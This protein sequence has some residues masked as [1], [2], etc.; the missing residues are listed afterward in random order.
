M[1]AISELFDATTIVVPCSRGDRDG[2][3]RDGAAPLQGHQLTVLPTTPPMGSGLRR[4]LQFPVWLLRNSATI[5]RA[6]RNADA[7]HAPIPGDVGTIG[8]VLAVV[9]RKPLFVRHCGNWL[10]PR[11]TAEHFWRWFV[12]RFAGGRN[13]MLATGGTAEAPSA[14][15][16]N[17][18]WIFSTSMS[19]AELQLGES[20]CTPPPAAARLI[21]VCRQDKAKG[22]DT[23]IDSL[24]LLMQGLPGIG[25]DVV[26]DG[27]HLEALRNRAASLGISD[28]VVFHGKQNHEAVLRLLRAAHL[29]VYPTRASEG[30]PKVVLEALACGLPVVTTR[31]SVL[32]QLLAD[33]A[34][35]L[36]DESVPAA[37]ARAVS[38]ALSDPDRYRRMSAS[39]IETAR[40]FSLERWR[41]TIGLA[42]RGAWGTPLRAHA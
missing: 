16:P 11:T 10:R 4:K 30:F 19:E 23:V 25:L 37:V 34:G 14:I 27:D 32:P 8:M 42:L 6:I 31:V 29:F 20:R 17:V 36:L 40:G 26:G 3:P 15:N 33:G 22:T 2:A 28:R 41:D 24:P 18:R 9:L 12:E 7:V 38:D 35:I 13:V 39:A 1:R 21:I 5:I